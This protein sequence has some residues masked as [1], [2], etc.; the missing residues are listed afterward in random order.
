MPNSENRLLKLSQWFCYLSKHFFRINKN[1]DCDCNKYFLLNSDSWERIVCSWSVRYPGSSK[2]V[3]QVPL[4]VSVPIQRSLHAETGR[5]AQQP[6]TFCPLRMDRNLAHLLSAIKIIGPIMQTL[7]CVNLEKKLWSPI[8][9]L[10]VSVATAYVISLGG[11][12]RGRVGDDAMFYL[13]TV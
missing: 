7:D 13:L 2:S 12:K 1:C 6:G 4:P 10:R 8:D 11:F 5:H 9:L 3:L